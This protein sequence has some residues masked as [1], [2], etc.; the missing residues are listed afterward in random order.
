MH[1]ILDSLQPV[2]ANSEHVRINETALEKFCRKI[3][4]NRPKIPEWD[5]QHHFYDGTERTVAYLLVLDSLNFCFWSDPLWQILYKGEI[6]SG[7][8][9]LAAALKRAIEEGIPI[10]DADF[11]STVPPETV[12][13]IFRGSGRLPLLEK[14]LEILHEI[15]TVLKAQYQGSAHRLVEAAQSS[16]VQLV[17][18]LVTDLHSFRDE[19]LYKEYPILFRKRAQIFVADLY[20]SFQG[21]RWG[22]FHDI[23]QLTIFADYVLPQVLRQLDILQYGPKLS[24][25]IDCQELIEPGSPEEVEIRAHTIWAVELIRRKLAA[26]NWNLR[27]FE[28]DWLLWNMGQDPGYEVKPYHRTLSIYY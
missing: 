20:G 1:E 27:A 18:R 17:Q 25:R 15:G 21:K 6:L 16:A 3:L 13:H 26:R 2:I 5:Y 24:D 14:R 12:S 7:Y 10:D 19:A 11:L 4:Q 23:D 8:M 28:I 22:E 9:A